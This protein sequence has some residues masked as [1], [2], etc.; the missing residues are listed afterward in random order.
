[1]KITAP[2]QLTILI[3]VV[4]AILGVIARVLYQLDMPWPTAG[5]ALLLVAY[6]VLLAGNLFEGI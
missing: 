2:T 5:F 6:L 3:S 4:L 1:M